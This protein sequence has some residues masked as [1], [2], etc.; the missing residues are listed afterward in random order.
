M[1]SETEEL[2]VRFGDVGTYDSV[3]WDPISLGTVFDTN[4]VGE[5][6]AW[7]DAGLIT[8]CFEGRNYISLF[9]GD[10]DANFKRNLS[11]GEKLQIEK[12]LSL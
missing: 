10:M 12:C 6:V 11:P 9:W 7:I 4:Y 8:T 5:F 3:C 2:W 1:Q